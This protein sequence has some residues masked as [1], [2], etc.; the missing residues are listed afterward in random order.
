MNVWLRVP[1]AFKALL[2]PRFYEA[3]LLVQSSNSHKVA[4]QTKQ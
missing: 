4:G 2:A 1:G 3:V